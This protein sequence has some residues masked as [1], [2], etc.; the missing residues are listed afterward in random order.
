MRLSPVQIVALCALL[1]GVLANTVTDPEA[2]GV[3]DTVIHWISVLAQMA[4]TA[5]AWLAL[6]PSAPP[7]NAVSDPSR[8]RE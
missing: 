5:A 2:Y 1:L 3:S 4:S 6:P 8:F 7:P